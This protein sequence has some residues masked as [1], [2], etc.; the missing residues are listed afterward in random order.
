MAKRNTGSKLAQ[1]K[2]SVQRRTQRQK[3]R[4]PLERAIE[5][6]TGA[7]TGAAIGF[8]RAKLADS[9]GDM[10]LPKTDI[11]AELVI[12]VLAGGMGVSGYAGPALSSVL[13]TVGSTA[14]GIHMAGMVERAAK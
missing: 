1:Y 8:M 2:A 12:G 9:N 14:L 10:K 11:D 6:G 4:L 5:V 13:T 7:A 3:A